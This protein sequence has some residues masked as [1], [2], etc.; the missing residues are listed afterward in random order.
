MG[1]DLIPLLLLSDMILWLYLKYK[2]RLRLEI[3][4]IVFGNATL[5][6]A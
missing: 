1:T 2:T 3:T 6:R 4:S 5:R